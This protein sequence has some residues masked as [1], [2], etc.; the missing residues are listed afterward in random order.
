MDECTIHDST[1]CLC[2]KSSLISLILLPVDDYSSL[3]FVNNGKLRSTRA[4]YEYPFL[5]QNRD[6]QR[7]HD[8]VLNIFH[9]GIIRLDINR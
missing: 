4:T 5:K 3:Q 1:H 7:V 6:L 9:D 2:A 8:F